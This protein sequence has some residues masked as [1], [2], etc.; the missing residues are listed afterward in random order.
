ML[1]R[2]S[3]SW[4][5]FLSLENKNI[6]NIF[7]VKYIKIKKILIKKKENILVKIRQDL[8]L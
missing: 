2:L 5:V 7:K 3:I 4:K 1:Y 6:N 8:H